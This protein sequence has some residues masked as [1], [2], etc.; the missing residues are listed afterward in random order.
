NFKQGLGE[1]NSWADNI[2]KKV[3]A[4]FFL[5][6]KDGIPDIKNPKNK[7]RLIAYLRDDNNVESVALLFMVNNYFRTDVSLPV[8]TMNGDDVEFAIVSYK[9]PSELAHNI[10][11]LFGAADLSPTLYRR[12]EKK[13]QELANIFQTTLCRTYTLEA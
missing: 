13:I 3:G 10:L 6:E 2:A 12:H 11:H 9:Y 5:T 8:N 1:L 7:E 4:S